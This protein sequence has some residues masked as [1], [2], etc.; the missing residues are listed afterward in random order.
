MLALGFCIV[1][2]TVLI[3]FDVLDL[4]DRDAMVNGGSSLAA[5]LLWLGLG[6]FAVA[7]MPG[8]RN[9]FPA[10]AGLMTAL[11]LVLSLGHNSSATAFSARE[12]IS[13]GR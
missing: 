2:P 4:D 10:F 9:A 8:L 11:I 3:E 1:V 6:W 5:P 12:K 13:D 7:L